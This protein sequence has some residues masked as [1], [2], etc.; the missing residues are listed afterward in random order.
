MGQIFLVCWNQNHLAPKISDTETVTIDPDGPGPQPAL[1]RILDRRRDTLG[2]ECATGILPV[3][4]GAAEHFTN[5][6]YDNSGRI[7][8]VTSPA[9]TFNYT[10][11]PGSSLIASVVGPIHTVTNTR[12]P[13][14]DVLASKENKI[15]STGTPVS[16]FTYTVN[17]LSQRTGVQTSGTAFNSAP[18]DWAWGNDA[19]GLVVSADYNRLIEGADDDLRVRVGPEHLAIDPNLLVQRRFGLG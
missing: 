12:E 14:H 9:V 6:G 5:Y 13:N 11:A 3:S 7:S 4:R 16:A 8:T 10:Y 19:L 1:T 18:A 15:N 17:P 2:R